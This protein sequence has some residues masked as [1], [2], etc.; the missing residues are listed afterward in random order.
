VVDDDIEFGTGLD[1]RNK[2]GDARDGRKDGHG[3]AKIA[4]AAPERL[5]ERRTNPVTVGS[6]GEAETNAAKAVLCVLAQVIGR[7]RVF[8][9]DAT[10]TVKF[11]GITAEDIEE[12]AV[13][14]AVVNDLNED[15]AGYAVACH[16]LE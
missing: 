15:R 11:A 13:V 10:D 4:A 3:D 14:P 5:H 8:G 16:Q 12:I 7:G 9:V 2:I 6:G 1:E